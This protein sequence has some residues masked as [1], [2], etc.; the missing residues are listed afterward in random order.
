M[1]NQGRVGS[2]SGSKIQ[3]RSAAWR[4]EGLSQGHEGGKES[5]W[6]RAES[7]GILKK[8]RGRCNMATPSVRKPFR[9]PLR[10]YLQTNEGERTATARSPQIGRSGGPADGNHRRALPPNFYFSVFPLTPHSSNRR[11][12]SLEGRAPKA[13]QRATIAGAE[14][15]KVPWLH[16]SGSPVS[17]FRLPVSLPH[18]HRPS[19]EE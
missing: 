12:G 11:G 8:F 13:A 7:S 1:E 16:A 2:P 15:V 9:L 18:P 19:K 10:K 14:G 3:A 6:R 5:G 17:G 4:E